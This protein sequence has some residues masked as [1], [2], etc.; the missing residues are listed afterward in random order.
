MNFTEKRWNVSGHLF[1]PQKGDPRSS[2]SSSPSPVPLSTLQYSSLIV[3]G[4]IWALHD[5]VLKHSSCRKLQRAKSFE[6]SK[7]KHGGPPRTV[8]KC[9]RK[10]LTPSRLDVQVDGYRR[11]CLFSTSPLSTCFKG[12]S[13]WL[14]QSAC[15]R[16]APPPG[17]HCSCAW[18]AVFKL[19][20][21]SASVSRG[22]NWPH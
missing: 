2:F 18:G 1:N 14:A 19:L 6:A 22:K 4:K 7:E 16:S 15:T 21:N 10:A 5:P 13:R 11:R 17:I 20:S 9:Q 3:G 8:H 12:Q